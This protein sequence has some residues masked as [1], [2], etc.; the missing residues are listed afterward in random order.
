[1]T[2]TARGDGAATAELGG[3]FVQQRDR[4]LGVFFDGLHAGSPGPR[5]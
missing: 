1:M 3:R 2:R 5:R 4:M